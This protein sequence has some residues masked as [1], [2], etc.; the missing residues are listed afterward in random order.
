MSGDHVS[1]VTL[2][3]KE[4]ILFSVCALKKRT[5]DLYQLPQ[6]NTDPFIPLATAHM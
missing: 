3:Q 2:E 4:E 5:R 1:R 6:I